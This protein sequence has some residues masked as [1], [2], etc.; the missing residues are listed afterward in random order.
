LDRAE[1]VVAIEVDP[2]LVH[3]L[4]QKFRDPIESGRLVLSETDI[5]KQIWPRGDRL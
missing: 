2:V 1:K 3:Y 4:R 5:L